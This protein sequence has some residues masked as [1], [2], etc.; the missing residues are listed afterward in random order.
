MQ[1]RLEKFIKSVYRGWK[2]DHS[3]GDKEHPDEETLACFIEGK[4]TE[5]ENA[6]LREHLIAC[7]NC[8]EAVALNLASAGRETKDIPEEALSRIKS[9]LVFRNEPSILE[10]ILK[11]KEKALEMINTTGDV[12]VGFELVPAPVL[13]S[14]SIKDFKDEVI[15]LKDF[16]DISVEVKIENKG[17]QV[18]NLNI[19]VKQKQTQKTIKDLRVALI[20]NDLELESYIS[21]LGTV[22]FEHVLFGKYTV[23]ISTIDSRLASILL[24]IKI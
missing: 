14:R 8:A 7:D 19:L 1:D 5:V 17:G 10:I 4:L 20:K 11:L 22:V 15:I 21:D 2:S 9:L 3:K 24:D 16:K 18:F 23:E 12:L 6:S 13:R